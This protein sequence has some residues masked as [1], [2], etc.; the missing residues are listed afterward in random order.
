MFMFLLK[1]TLFYYVGISNLMLFIINC[2]GL[3]FRWLMLNN[4][5]LRKKAL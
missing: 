3:F 1:I 4:L 2:V 5:D